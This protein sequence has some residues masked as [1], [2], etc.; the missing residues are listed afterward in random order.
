MNSGTGPFEKTYQDLRALDRFGIKLGLERVNAL[1]DHLDRPHQTFDSI[2]IAGSKGKG[3]VCTLL[4]S[5]LT[6]S[7]YRVGT[8]LSPHLVHERERILIDMEPVSESKLGESL[9]A[10][11]SGD[12]GVKGL[13]HFEVLTA[14]AFKIFADERMDLAVVE[15]GMGGR[16]DATNVLSPLCT[17]ITQIEIEH[18]KY[19]GNDIPCITREK[20]AIIKEEEFCVTNTRGKAYRVVEE[21]CEERNV[22]LQRV[23]IGT[24]SGKGWDVRDISLS[25]DH[26]TF[27]LLNTE[28]GKRYDLDVGRVGEH[29]ALNAGTAAVM[30]DLLDSHTGYSVAKKDIQLGIEAAGPYL[31]GR[32]E[33]TEKG[34]KRYL[35]DVAHTPGSTGAL[36]K[37]LEHIPHQKTVFLLA[38]LKDK[39]LELIISLLAPKADLLICC[40]TASPR[41]TEAKELAARANKQ[42]IPCQAASTVKEGL[43]IARN[44]A[45]ENDII[46]ITGSFTIVGEA[47]FHLSKQ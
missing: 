24:D 45:A 6:T 43:E 13:T 36:C 44:N 32:T 11:L 2:H 1:L 7:G 41:S 42:G 23:G 28:Y 20:A 46:V 19:L 22:P 40:S 18:S 15:V 30:A 39:N 47:L 29:H 31:G 5:I 33:Q 27:T 8:Y 4:S 25:S 14:A 37:A 3:S 21:R 26:T 38:L 17:A 10:I 34:G 35:L 9:E 16:L 12:H